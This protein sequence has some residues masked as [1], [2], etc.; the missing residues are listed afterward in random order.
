MG[1]LFPNSGIRPYFL[2]INQFLTFKY[3]IPCF[4]WQASNICFEHTINNHHMV[5]VMQQTNVVIFRLSIISRMNYLLIRNMNCLC[6]IVNFVVPII[7]SGEQGFHIGTIAALGRSEYPVCT[8]DS[9]RAANA[10]EVN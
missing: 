5:C 10:L 2:K 4:S 1:A 7:G 6:I 8:N 3:L 9:A